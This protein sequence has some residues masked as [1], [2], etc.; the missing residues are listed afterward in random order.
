MPIT[1]SLFVGDQSVVFSSFRLGSVWDGAFIPPNTGSS[2]TII[3]LMIW[4]KKEAYEETTIKATAKRL[5]YLQKNCPLNNPE[6]IKTFIANK[7]CSNAFKECLIETYDIYMRAI[8]QTWGKPVYKRYDK[9]PKIPTEEKIDMLI[10]NAPPQMALIMSMSKDMGTRPVEL[11]WL[12]V[13]DINL[14]NGIV[15]ITGA[16]HTVGRIGKLKPQTLEMLKHFILKRNLNINDTIFRILSDSICEQYRRYR[17]KL[18]EKL[19]DPTF[20]TIRLYDFR[21]FFATM[22]YHKTKDLLHVKTLLGHRDIKTT[23]RYTQLLE[24]LPND[25]YHCKTA[26]NINEATQLIEN[27]FEYVTEIEGVKLFRKRK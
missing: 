9:L 13:L 6:I 26:N 7:K 23:L 1:A 16:K 19:Q 21:H 14:Q 17:N 5:K 11:T 8:G 2:P 22:E 15:N 10:A 25:E 4:M 18:A 20:K 3:N 27:G 24:S 12:K